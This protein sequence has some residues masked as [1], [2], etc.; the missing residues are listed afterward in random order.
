ME[1]PEGPGTYFPSTRLNNKLPALFDPQR[2]TTSYKFFWFLALL[3]HVERTDSYTVSIDD[4]IVDM[5]VQAW[6]PVSLFCLNLGKADQL[7]EV[8]ATLRFLPKSNK[9]L[10]LH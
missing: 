7:S 10:K 8:V 1:H 9:T 4:L 6:H 5:V 3:H 2:T